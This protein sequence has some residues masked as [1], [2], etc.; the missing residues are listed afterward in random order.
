MYE[1]DNK[2]RIIQVKTPNEH[3]KYININTTYSANTITN[4][5]QGQ[6]TKTTQDISGND[7]SIVKNN[8]QTISYTYDALAIL[9]EPIK[10]T[11]LLP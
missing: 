2:N 8:Q 1:Y 10:T 6:I 3:G 4:N 5:N 11:V 7:K 9:L